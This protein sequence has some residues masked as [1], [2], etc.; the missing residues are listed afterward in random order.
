MMI[1]KE[2]LGKET[3]RHYKH[4]VLQF[5]DYLYRTDY[6]K[7]FISSDVIDDWI[8][9]ISEGIR[10]NT[11]GQYIHYIRQLLYHLISCG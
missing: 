7:K 8:K 11:V 3:F 9:E 5:D 6:D 2:E 10:I 4:V 1:R